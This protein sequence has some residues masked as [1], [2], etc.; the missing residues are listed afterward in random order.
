MLFSVLLHISTLGESLTA[1]ITDE[2]LQTFMHTCMVQEVPA[3]CKL[4]ATV[5]VLANDHSLVSDG[6]F[7]RFIFKLKSFQDWISVIG[8]NLRFTKKTG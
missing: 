7:T 4:F 1:N 8:A 2:G 6:V 3:F 5:S